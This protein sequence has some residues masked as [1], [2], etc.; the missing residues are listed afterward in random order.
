MIRKRRDNQDRIEMYSQQICLHE[1]IRNAKMGGRIN[2]PTF[3]MDFL[4]YFRTILPNHYISTSF[5][6]SMFGSNPASTTALSPSVHPLT[7]VNHDDEALELWKEQE[8]I[9]KVDDIVEDEDVEGW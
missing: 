4:P 8:E 1:N 2:T 5:L 7:I 9:L 6:D 3:G